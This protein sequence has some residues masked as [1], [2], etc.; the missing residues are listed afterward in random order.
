[1]E[2]NIVIT[3]SDMLKKEWYLASRSAMLSNMT[4]TILANI[5]HNNIISKSLPDFVSA[6]YII[7]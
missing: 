3:H 2:K 6:S 4:K 5:A 1:M 7:W